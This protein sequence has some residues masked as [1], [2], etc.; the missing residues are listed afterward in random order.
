MT[1]AATLADARVAVLGGLGFIGS[2]LVRTLVEAGADVVVVDSLDER[3]GGLRDHLAGLAEDVTLMVDDVRAPGVADRA[4]DGADVVFNLVGQ[5]S[6]LDSMKDPL[7]DLETNCGAQLAI[8]ES[9]RARAAHA[10]VVFAST[11]QLYGRPQYLPV[12]E[13]HPIVP[14]DVNG[15]HK[16]AGEEYH[17]LYREVYDLHVSILRLTNTYGP[18]MRVRDARHTF[19]GEWVRRALADEEIVVF[20]DGSQRRDLN[21]VD[22]VVEALVVAAVNARAEL[23]VYNLGSREVVSLLE[24]ARLL[25]R[26]AGGGHVRCVAFPAERK[27]IDIGDYYADFTRIGDELGWQPSTS[28]ADGLERT[29]AYFRAAGAAPG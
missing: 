10:K 5:T 2:N 12:D 20:G 26:L 18:R 7:G 9:V 8:L 3:Y 19:L 29:L 13:R 16:L 6:H 1:S 14:V 28:L 21:Y 17:R 25:A 15:I 23:S 24:L 11:R 4:V 27:V 22:D